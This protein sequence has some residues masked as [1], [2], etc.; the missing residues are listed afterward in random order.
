VVFILKSGINYF[1]VG[2]LQSK[3]I[4]SLHEFFISRSYSGFVLGFCFI[5]NCLYSEQINHLLDLEILSFTMFSI[6]YNN[7]S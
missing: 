7:L 3:F 5:Y 4:N 1:S 2:I 6:Y